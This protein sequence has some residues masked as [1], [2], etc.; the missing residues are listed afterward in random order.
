MIPDEYVRLA[1]TLVAAAREAA[2]RTSNGP[3]VEIKADGTPVTVLD[4]AVTRAA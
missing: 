1:E 3:G 2:Q 4:R